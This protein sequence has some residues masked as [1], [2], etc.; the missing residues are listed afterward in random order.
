SMPGGWAVRIAFGCDHR[1]L[2]LKRDLI[3][4]ATEMRHICEDMGCYDEVSV[5]YPDNAG[6]V[7]RD[8]A[9]KECE[10]GCC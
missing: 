10:R 7:G 8:V 4:H 6:K 3:R 5:D 2:G 9:G 1:A